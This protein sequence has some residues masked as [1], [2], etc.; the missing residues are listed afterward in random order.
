VE[1]VTDNRVDSEAGEF[2]LRLDPA[3]TEDLWGVY[4]HR[5]EVEQS[6]GSTASWRG[7]VIVTA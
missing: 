6:G 5:P 4:Y 1:I 7:E 2:E 3:A